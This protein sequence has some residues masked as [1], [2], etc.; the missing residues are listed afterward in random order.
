MELFD[1]LAR[2]IFASFILTN[3]CQ[4]KGADGDRFGKDCFGS[5][6]FSDQLNALNIKMQKWRLLLVNKMKN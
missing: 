3:G 1:K 6:H 5:H 4:S 2:T